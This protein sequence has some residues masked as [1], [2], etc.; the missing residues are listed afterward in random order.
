MGI[1]PHQRET[2]TSEESPT[3]V[4]TSKRTILQLVSATVIGGDYSPN[5]ELHS[6]NNY[7]ISQRV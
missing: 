3:P 7:E 1:S 2:T 4:L 6:Q 5:R